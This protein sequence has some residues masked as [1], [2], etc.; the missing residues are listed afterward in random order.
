MAFSRV[1]VLDAG[2]VAVLNGELEL[3]TE[4]EEREVE[5][6]PELKELEKLETSDMRGTLGAGKEV[7]NT[8]LELK[9]ELEDS[10][11]EELELEK[12][13]ELELEKLE[14]EKLELEELL[15]KELELKLRIRRL[16]PE[17]VVLVKFIGVGS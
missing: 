17:E 15:L 6:M 1:D 2:K 14:L 13:E 3:V 10:K 12:L 16:E 5:L 11:L 9:L 4:L 7:V 8:E